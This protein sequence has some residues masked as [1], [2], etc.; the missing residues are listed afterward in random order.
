MYSSSAEI[1]SNNPQRVLKML[2]NHWRH[3]FQIDNK[4]EGHARINLDDKGIAEFVVSGEMLCATASHDSEE[5]LPALLVAIEN[6][7]Q[8]FAKDETL[9]FDWK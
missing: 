2:C 1:R 3:R 5:N 7:L 4:H 9:V 8:R 6:H